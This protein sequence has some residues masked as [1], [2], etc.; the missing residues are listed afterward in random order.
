[1]STGAEIGEANLRLSP[2][3]FAPSPGRARVAISEGFRGFDSAF[4]VQEFSL[5]IGGKVALLPTE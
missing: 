2:A 1:V 3:G 5:S 4:Y